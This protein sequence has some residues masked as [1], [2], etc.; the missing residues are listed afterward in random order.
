MTTVYNEYFAHYI[1]LVNSVTPLQSLIETQK[2]LLLLLENA[3]EKQGNYRYAD[4]KW[5]VK[6]VVA[7]IIDAERVFAYRAMRFARNDKTDLPG[8]DENTYAQYSNAKNR[9]LSEL[10]VEFDI[11]RQSS[12]ELFRSFNDEALSRTGTANKMPIDVKS[13]FYLIAGHCQHHLNILRERYGL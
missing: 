9:S 4:E 13:I 6:E 1:N 2:E 7:H 8:Y 3:S 5:T 12:I 10:K 11:L